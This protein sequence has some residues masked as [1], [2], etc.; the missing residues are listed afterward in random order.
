VSNVPLPEPHLAGV[1]AAMLLHRVR[2]WTLPGPRRVHLLTGAAPIAAG[3]W[4]VV[5]SVWAARQVNL[6]HPGQLVTTGPYA[7]SR[8]PMYA[9]WALLHAG[10]G[11]AAGSGWILATLPA[12]TGLVHRQVRQE[13][14]DLGADFGDE[15]A[16]YQAAVPRYL[17]PRSFTGKADRGARGGLRPYSQCEYPLICV[18]AVSL[19]SI[20]SATQIPA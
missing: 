5:W 3:G 1:T 16:R 20:T 12:A 6:A 19:T 15:F 9:G 11:V 13:E 4:L 18:E 2:P 8:N 17:R 10:A 7:R 14:H